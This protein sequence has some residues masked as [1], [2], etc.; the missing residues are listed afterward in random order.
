MINGGLGY[1]SRPSFAVRYR[2]PIDKVG[3]YIILRR[4]IIETK[5]GY[6]N[7]NTV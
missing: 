7:V 1:I 4:V 6:I 2:L 5:G 3:I